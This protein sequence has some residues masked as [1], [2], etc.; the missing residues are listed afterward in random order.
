MKTDRRRTNGRP[1]RWRVRGLVLVVLLAMAPVS[2]AAAGQV[3]AGEALAAKDEAN[4]LRDELRSLDERREVIE[5][6]PRGR[7]RSATTWATI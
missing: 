3:T 7:R 2:A 5:A 1:R 4:Q 6:T